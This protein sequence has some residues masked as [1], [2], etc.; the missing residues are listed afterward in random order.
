MENKEDKS[1]D[2]YH[3]LQ[4]KIYQNCQQIFFICNI[5][6]IYYEFNEILLDIDNIKKDYDLKYN[7]TRNKIFNFYDYVENLNLSSYQKKGFEIFKNCILHILMYYFYLFYDDINTENIQTIYI[8]SYI[9]TYEFIQKLNLLDYK[10]EN[11]SI[12]YIEYLNLFYYLNFN[13]DKD[14]YY[15]TKK[16]QYLAD[17]SSNYFKYYLNLSK[18]FDNLYDCFSDPDEE[19]NFLYNLDILNV[20]IDNFIYEGYEL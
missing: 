13:D 3:R 14:K 15:K 12:I 1:Y 17:K 10:Y 7:I 4:N 6:N 8:L 5:H 11:K 19:E 20:H 18:V 2:Y 9:S 16:E